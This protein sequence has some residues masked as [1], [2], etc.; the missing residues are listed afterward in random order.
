[1]N[2]ISG[3]IVNHNSIYDGEIDF[4]KTINE[5][6]KIKK[7]KVNNYIIPGFIDLHCHGGN[8][9]D[10]M[11]GADAIV[12]MSKYHLMHGTTSIMPTTWTNNFEKIFKHWIFNN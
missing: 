5:I 6:K 7:S 12:A 11:D 10:T 2:K 1:M 4:D 3:T 9:F 8:G